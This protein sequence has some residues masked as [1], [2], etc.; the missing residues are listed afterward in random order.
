[1]RRAGSAAQEGGTKGK[2]VQEK[3]ILGPV[4]GSEHS[5]WSKLW[6]VQNRGEVSPQR[7]PQTTPSTKA[8]SWEHVPVYGLH[9]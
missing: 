2:T 6:T 3:T 5:A 9:S 4:V 7:T 1:M 8:F